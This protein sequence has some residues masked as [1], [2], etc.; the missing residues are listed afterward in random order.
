MII[1]FFL[2][3]N[4]HDS[5]LYYTRMTVGSILDVNFFLHFGGKCY[6]PRSGGMCGIFCVPVQSLSCVFHIG[7]GDIIIHYNHVKFQSCVVSFARPCVV[8]NK[9]HRP[10]EQLRC[11]RNCQPET[12][13]CC[14][15]TTR[16]TATNLFRL[17]LIKILRHVFTEGVLMWLTPSNLNFSNN[18][19][20]ESWNSF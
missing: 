20:E 12:W 11:R 6:T 14:D 16:P 19:V 15:R 5:Y 17:L 18:L 1:I 13:Q 10:T 9:V 7:I 8:N 2:F 3:S 4:E